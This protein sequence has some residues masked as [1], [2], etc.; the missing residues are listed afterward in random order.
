MGHMWEFLAP[1]ANTLVFIAVG[2]TVDMQLLLKSMEFIPLTLL[3]VI[4]ARAIAISVVVPLL[5][6]FKLCQP[7]S[8]RSQFIMFW[9]GSWLHSFKGWSL[10]KTRGDSFSGV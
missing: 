7:I 6:Q 4:A 8:L 1:S 5:N 3:V 9:G 2:L 10:L